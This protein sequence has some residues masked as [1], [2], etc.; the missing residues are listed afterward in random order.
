MPKNPNQ[1]SKN[2]GLPRTSNALRPQVTS[3]STRQTKK[4]S[5]LSPQQGLLKP[6]LNDYLERLKEITS[7]PVILHVVSGYRTPFQSAP[8]QLHVPVTKCSDSTAP[9]L[10]AEVNKL[11]SV[12]AIKAIPFSKENFYSRL[13]LVPKKEGT[14]R[15]VIDLSRLNKFVENF[16]FQME[17]LSCLKT[18]LREG[19]FMTCIDLKDAYLSVHVRESSLKYLYF[20]WRNRCYAFQGLPFGL[21][22]APRVLTNEIMIDHR[23]YTLNLSS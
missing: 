12:G 16:H 3:L 6:R 17:N 23:S 1:L 9:L 22:T 5:V 19:D 11:L 4:L 20:Q 2:L 7:Y 10:D 8:V 15:L 21:N 18:L 13:F 14:Y